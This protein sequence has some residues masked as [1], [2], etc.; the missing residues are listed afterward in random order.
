VEQEKLV[1]A[2]EEYITNTLFKRLEDLQ[3][4]K[5][6]LVLEVEREEEYLTNTLQKKLELLQQDKVALENKLEI[7]EESIVN[8][9]QKQLNELNHEKDELEQKLADTPRGTELRKLKWELDL[10]KRSKEGEISRLQS[11]NFGLQQQ[12]HK[13][14]EQYETL[15]TEKKEL[16]ILCKNSL[17]SEDPNKMDSC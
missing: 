2:E 7:E 9:L 8:R 13:Y 11:E 6:D 5:N 1:E 12:I 10:V 15:S 4:E 3:N 17:T 16:E 14:K